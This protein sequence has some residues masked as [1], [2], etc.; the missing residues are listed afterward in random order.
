[1]KQY[2]EINVIREQIGERFGFPIEDVIEDLPIANDVQEK[3]YCKMIPFEPDCR[4]YTEFFIC[5]SCHR[6]VRLGFIHKDYSGNYCIECG[7]EVADG[8]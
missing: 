1:M 8:D 7:A 2:V 3:K 6:H 4:G 5:T